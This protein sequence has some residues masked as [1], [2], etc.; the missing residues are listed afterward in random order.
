MI[1]NKNNKKSWLK[2]PRVDTGKNVSHSNLI[3]RP[4]IAP[5]KEERSGYAVSLLQKACHLFNLLH[6]SMD[7]ETPH[8][9][10]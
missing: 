5:K 8:N 4:A 10:I 9:G 1:E 7:R 6:H 2:I 3:Q